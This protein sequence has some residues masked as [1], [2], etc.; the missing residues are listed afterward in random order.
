MAISHRFLRLTQLL[1]SNLL[2]VMA[3][4]YLLAGVAPGLGLAI[5]RIQIGEVGFFGERPVALSLTNLLLASM[6]FTAGLGVALR[7]VRQIWQ[8]PKLLLAGVLANALMPVLF[9]AACSLLARL[10]TETDEAQSMLVGLALIG[11][12][13]VAG[14]ASVWTQNA[15][16]NVPL[17]VGLVLAST[18]L[19]P[20]SIPLALHAASHFTTGDYASDLAEIAG[21]GT[22]TF[23]LLS[24]V[25]PCFA[26]IV[27]RH[28]AGDERVARVMPWVKALNLVVLLLL[29]YS[30]AS[31]A[32]HVI[33]ADP[34]YD[35]LAL[36]FLITAAMCMSSFYVGFGIARRLR[37]RQPDVT[38]LTFGV[39][40][41]NSSASSVLAAS[42]LADH[43]LVLIPILA[44]GMLQKVLAGA[45]D[46]ALRKERA[47]K[48][49]EAA[50]RQGS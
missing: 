24:V 49:A 5:K 45:V 31:G 22:I 1:Q 25:L 17:T 15:E 10:W 44:Y 43:P 26:G 41:N 16:G 12:M 48:L 42:R 6:L 3:A 29:S 36:M 20:L 50:A 38:S 13:P 8:Q 2:S 30:N 37:A 11:A 19:S 7:D 28:L 21:D 40:M 46:A 4:I 34:D 35:M 23:S 9:L 47:R 27:A 39:G 14:G 32:M 33:V 18:L